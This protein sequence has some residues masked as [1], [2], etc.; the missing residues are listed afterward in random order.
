MG[1]ENGS[2]YDTVLSRALTVLHE[3]DVCGYWLEDYSDLVGLNGADGD[4]TVMG[5]SGLHMI[6]VHVALPPTRFQVM[7][8][9]KN[10]P[11]NL[12]TYNY[13]REP[14]VK[15]GRVD[16]NM[17]YF[18]KLLSVTY[19]RVYGELAE[20]TSREY[21]EYIEYAMTLRPEDPLA[22]YALLGYDDTGT[23]VLQPDVARVYVPD[24]Y[25][26]GL[27]M[28]DVATLSGVSMSLN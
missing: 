11:L 4:L 5:E 9:D 20:M 19:G 8:T 28:R 3:P 15:N 12:P 14:N 1:K 10:I 13:V 27:A 17:S 6:H 23:G 18:R 7:H 22:I 16:Y 2:Q 21:Q 24:G 26:F 25:S